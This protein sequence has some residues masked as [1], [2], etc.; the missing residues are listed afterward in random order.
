MDFDEA[1]DRGSRNI[2]TFRFQSALDFG[3]SQEIVI[4]PV[5]NLIRE[6]NQAA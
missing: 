4:P 1:H 2:Q 6:R 5:Q 3:G